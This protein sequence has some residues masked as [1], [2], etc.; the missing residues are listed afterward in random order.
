MN[1]IAAGSVH[2]HPL[3]KNGALLRDKDRLHKETHLHTMHTAVLDRM[4]P[5][6]WAGCGMD[7]TACLLITK[8]KHDYREANL[9][10]QVQDEANTMEPKN[11]G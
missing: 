4:G 5:G 10:L 9:S 3:K 8:V 6:V 1:G 7:I 11:H 2:K